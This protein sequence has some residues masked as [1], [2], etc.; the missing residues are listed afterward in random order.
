MGLKGYIDRINLYQ[1]SGWVFDTENPDIKQVV[2]LYVGNEFKIKKR[3]EIYRADLID[4]GK[5]DGKCAFI[6]PIMHIDIPSNSEISVKVAGTDFYILNKHKIQNLP[7]LEFDTKPLIVEGAG[8]SGSTLLMSLLGTSNDVCF[9]KVFPYEQRYLTYFIM[10]VEGFQA[11]NL[12]DPPDF[13]S[14]GPGKGLWPIPFDIKGVDEPRSFSRSMFKAMWGEL[15]SSLNKTG[16][17][18]KY[19]AEKI[20]QV[21]APR[22][23]KALGDINLR[24]LF[25]IR[26]PRSFVV[27]VFNYCKKRNYYDFGVKK[28]DTIESYC[29]RNKRIFSWRLNRALQIKGNKVRDAFLVRYEDLVLNVD[30]E[31][32]RISEWL[33]LR[34]P[35]HPDRV[36]L[37][38]NH[39]T[40][41]SPN[42][43]IA[44][45]ESI[46][47]K[48]IR[49]FF[50]SN[51]AKELEE[52][53]YM[54]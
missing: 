23:S 45:W 44:A 4:A 32:R 35:I 43:S 1:V 34:D 49:D 7:L 52:L 41:Q 13:F 14:Q 20:P 30:E 8:R 40:S 6:I 19:Y 12:P 26:D 48:D 2:E 9:E 11:G 54:N 50:E 24:T 39:M 5:G 27:S 42:E 46:L 3:A 36:K 10:I 22:I 47:S 21:F 38:K 29:H 17:E 18:K 25:H 15:L 37:T 33:D 53:G 28:G 31:A 51:F 16:S